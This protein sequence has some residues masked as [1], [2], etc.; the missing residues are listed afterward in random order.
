MREQLRNESPLFLEIMA[1]LFVESLWKSH[2]RIFYVKPQTCPRVENASRNMKLELF[3]FSGRTAPLIALDTRSM[4]EPRRV[5][6]PAPS[7][8]G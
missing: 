4:T 5:G 1:F 7:A 6:S 2:S 3:V 8:T